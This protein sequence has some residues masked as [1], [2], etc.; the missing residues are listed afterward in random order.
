MKTIAFH[1][2]KGGTG[3]TTLSGSVAWLSADAGKETVLVD[4]D[5]QGNA[6]TWFVTEP[7]QYELADVLLGNCK[8]SEALV[9]VRDHLWML[10][11]FGIGG[12]LFRFD[13]ATTML[14]TPHVFGDLVD[15]L[16]EKGFKVAIFDLSP[17]MGTLEQML[18]KEL[19]EVVTPLLPE[20]FGLDGIEIFRDSLA[21]LNQ[22]Q[23]SNV[24]HSKI[25]V[26]M[27]NRSFRRHLDILEDIKKTPGYQVLE[28]GQ[29]AKV[30]EAQITNQA[31]FEYAP[32]SRTVEDLRSLA[33]AV[34]G[35]K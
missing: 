1:I 18:L 26:N 3:K 8:L 27:I 13:D 16:E 35:G 31:V 15:G 11:T 5:P 19:D 28:I 6:S 10:P 32:G 2:Q 4:A 33:A 7:P 30:A 23:R 29:D 21:K 25:V 22:E 12:Q 24:S 20:H 17:G 9:M 34:L 14:R